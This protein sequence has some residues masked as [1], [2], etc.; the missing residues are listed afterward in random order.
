[1]TRR[2]EQ[3]RNHPR[4]SAAPRNARKLKLDSGVWRYYVTRNYV[5]LWTP[6]GREHVV[7]KNPPVAVSVCGCG[8]PY[9]CLPER[10]V[11]PGSLRRYIEQHLA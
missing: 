4:I 6:G 7:R 5:H 10:A 1:M 3:A 9:N 11:T 8:E 2:E